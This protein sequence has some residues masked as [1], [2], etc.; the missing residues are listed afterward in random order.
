MSSAGPVTATFAFRSWVLL[1]CAGG[2]VQQRIE[3]EE[4]LGRA[5]GDLGLP[6]SETESV[7]AR[8]WAGRP[9]DARFSTA[10]PWETF[11]GMQGMSVGW[12]LAWAVVFFAGFVAL[13]LLAWLTD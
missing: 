9:R 3:S 1:E 11:W 13:V 10:R 5:L 8:I 12:F 6:A 2:S 4:E 7:A